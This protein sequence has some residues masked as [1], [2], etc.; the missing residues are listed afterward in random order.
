MKLIVYNLKDYKDCIEVKYVQ[1]ENV[2][3]VLDQEENV[4]VNY[5]RKFYN[6]LLV[7]LNI[8]LWLKK[9]LNIEE[10]MI[11]TLNEIQ[12]NYYLLIYNIYLKNILF[13]LY[14]EQVVV[15]LK[16]IKLDC[17]DQLFKQNLIDEFVISVLGKCP[18]TETSLLLKLYDFNLQY[19]TKIFNV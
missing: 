4:I 10:I 2:V 13:F 3:D 15:L 18:F 7:I 11:S 12:S 1:E 9:L 8:F 16:I 17:L 5:S 6:K 19:D 14:V